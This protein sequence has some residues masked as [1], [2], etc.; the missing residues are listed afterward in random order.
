MRV[1]RRSLF[2]FLALSPLA[3]L[4]PATVKKPDLSMMDLQKSVNELKAQLEQPITVNVVIDGKKMA[5]LVVPHIP[6]VAM[7]RGL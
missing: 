3:L 7:R 1:T 5:E 2:S 6:S 4:K